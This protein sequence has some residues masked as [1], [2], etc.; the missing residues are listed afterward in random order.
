MTRADRVLRRSSL[1]KLFL[2]QL[3]AG[4]GVASGYAVG[5][6]LAEEITGE[7]AMA[8]FAQMSTI[9]GAGLLAYPLSALAARSGRRFALTLGFG[10]GLIGVIVVLLGVML[11]LLPLFM[12][13]MM[14]CGSAVAAGLQARYAAVDASGGNRPGSAMALIVW[15]TTV[16][17]VLGPNFM[18]PGAALGESI[19]MNPLAGPYLISMTCFLLATLAAFTLA[20]NRRAEAR[21]DTSA[22][23][24][25]ARGSVATPAT[26]ANQVKLLDAL[27][28]AASYPRVRFAVIAL[29]AGQMVMTNVM[30][31]TPVHMNHQHF[32]LT[33]V[34][35]VISIHI[36]GM[37]VFSPIFGWAA[38]RFGPYAVIAAGF[39]VYTVTITLGI[40]DALAPTS[41]MPLLST[42]LFFL[43]V[44]WSLFLIG[45]SALLVDSSP[46]HMRVPL[47]G[48]S[49]SAMNLG[50]ALMAAFAG[51]MLQVGG[52]ALINAVAGVVVVIALGFALASRRPEQPAVPNN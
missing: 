30:V 50:G 13:G 41:S 17:S 19:G 38:D 23:R 36:L 47:Q 11:T 8:G 40:L 43:G 4:A 22:P 39:V 20:P 46:E 2:S 21:P 9:L 44:G 51:M 34:G 12:F 7:T 29:I 42:A 33:A 18:T 6:M 28:F 31:M 1:T 37:Y 49:D 45:G 48:V 52:F 10:I 5:A 27:R 32:D 26:P 3:F 16:G 35:F 14:L 15:A 24:Q 25:D